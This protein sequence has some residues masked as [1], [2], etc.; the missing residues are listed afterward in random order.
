[1]TPIYEQF[2]EGLDTPDLRAAAT[3]LA[4]LT[5]SFSHKTDLTP[6]SGGR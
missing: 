2:T 6:L 3:L 1:M 5:A 4:Q